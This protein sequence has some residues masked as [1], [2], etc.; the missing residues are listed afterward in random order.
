[1]DTF[2]TT[3]KTPSHHQYH[4]GSTRPLGLAAINIYFHLLFTYHP[5]FSP[6]DY[7]PEGAV[8]IDPKDGQHN[9]I[10][11]TQIINLDLHESS[12]H[13]YNSFHPLLISILPPRGSNR[14][15][16]FVDRRDSQL[17]PR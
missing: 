4:L 10:H 5:S 16:P 1:M 13:T 11:D 15:T 12:S 2:I 9:K 7:W 17:G 14:T 3:T 6:T 8:D